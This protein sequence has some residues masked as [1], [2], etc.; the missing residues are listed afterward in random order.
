MTRTVYLEPGED[1]IVYGQ[2]L[3]HT[4]LNPEKTRIRIKDN[5]P[6]PTEE[7]PPPLPPDPDPEPEEPPVPAPSGPGI[8]FDLDATFPASGKAW[9]AIVS[10]SNQA[11]LYTLA[12]QDSP[13]NITT[14]ARAIVARRTKDPTKRKAVIDD[15]KHVRTT[16]PDRTLAL[17]RELG[18]APIAA[19]MV[20]ATDAELGYDFGGWLDDIIS[21]SFDGKTLESM[22][23]E[24]P[25]NWGTHGQ[26]ALASVYAYL[27]DT[28]GLDGLHRMVLGWCGDR[29]KY[30]GF[31]Y[32]DLDW[33]GDPSKPVGINS[34][35]ATIQGRNVDG[36]LPEEM[37][38]SGGFAWPPPKQNYCWEAL[39]GTVMAAVILERT[40]RPVW[41]ASD[42]AILRAYRWLVD[43]A[44]YPPSGDDT[45][46]TPIINA[47]YGTT[48]PV[49]SPVGHGKNLA[50][51]DWWA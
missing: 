14:L 26:G 39:Q 37:R 29:A 16:K 48:Y 44:Q 35:G 15:L 27:G 33:Q 38:R 47:A 30:A 17:A 1:V 9:E 11:G 36:A 13:S 41:A 3:T 50:F 40:G 46:I 20:G 45:F 34:V 25:N 8:L 22:T 28:A 6:A 42:K 19:E 5:R 21:Q 23:R 24:R 51:S 4:K 31:S 10:A 12:S 32:G 18:V 49:S 2:K 43:V 7:P